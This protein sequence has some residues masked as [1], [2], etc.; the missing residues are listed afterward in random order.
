[1]R[2][3]KGIPMPRPTPR[4]TLSA[5]SLLGDGFVD[6][7]DIEDAVVEK[8]VVLGVDVGEAEEVVEDEITELDLSGSLMYSIPLSK[9]PSLK[10]SAK[11]NSSAIVSSSSVWGVHV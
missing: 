1:M 5:S 6:I 8:S 3:R 2:R 11:W 10:V 4:P 7:V 9:F